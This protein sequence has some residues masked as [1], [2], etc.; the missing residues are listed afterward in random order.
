MKTPIG[1]AL[2]FAGTILLIVPF[3][4]YLGHLSIE[5]E[6]VTRLATGR[7]AVSVNYGP[8]FG[9]WQ[10]VVGALGFLMIL[11]GVAGTHEFK[12]KPKN[13]SPAPD[14]SVL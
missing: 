8:A 4:Y 2:I 5:T 7:G 12:R 1:V 10:N 6:A 13:A 11:G 14:A 9:L 3:A